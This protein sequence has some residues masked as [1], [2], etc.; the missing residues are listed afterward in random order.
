MLVSLIKLGI[1][2]FKYNCGFGISDVGFWHYQ[3][4]SC[5]VFY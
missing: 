4:N 5:D 2:N 1:E 3:T